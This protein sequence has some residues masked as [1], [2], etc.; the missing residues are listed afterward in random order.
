MAEFIPT[1]PNDLTKVDASPTK[2]FF[3]DI[4]TKDI[5]IDE[6]ILDLVDNSIDGAKRLRPGDEADY[7]GLFVDITVNGKEFEIADNCGG[8]PL[9]IARKYAF[10][11]GRAAGFV[12]TDSSVGQFGIGMKRALFKMA[13][14]FSVR[15][16]EPKYSYGI[17]VNVRKWA[18]DDINWDFDI[19]ELK[20][21]A[22]EEYETKT[23]LHINELEPA[24]AQVLES[25]TFGR[26]LSRDIRVR[27]LDAMRRNLAITLNGETII[28]GDLQ[29][30]QGAIVTSLSRKFEDPIGKSSLR[31]RLYVGV[32][33]SDRLRAG[34][35][36]FCNGRCILEADQTSETG[37]SAA[38]EGGVSM[39][40][41]HGQFARFRGYA[42]LDA[43]DASILPWNT[44]KTGLDPETIAYRK[45]FPRLIEAARP[46]INFLNAL[47]AEN[48]LAPSERVLSTGLNQSPA[49]SLERLPASLSFIYREP[50]ER[51]PPMSNIKYR[52]LTS[53]VNQLKEAMGVATLPLLGERSFEFAYEN[54]VEDE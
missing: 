10:K 13:R 46:V 27:H 21:G 17:D 28:P 40:K 15:S 39:P 7:R 11:F 19:V 14:N 48:D 23:L 34:W 41:Y 51:G 12:P 35:Y 20:A 6:A 54:L 5:R 50:P 2:A 4:I 32:G 42:F 52:R 30:K 38:V 45:L 24:V 26:A 31:T 25:E 18:S 16:I 53:E 37:W 33:D 9:D 47:D 8:I 1:D 49:M 22:F 43:Q 44:T 3:V 36:I 29:L